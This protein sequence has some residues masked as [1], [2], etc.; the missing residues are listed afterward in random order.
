MGNP[1]KLSRM[2]FD[3]EAYPSVFDVRHNLR[4]LQQDNPMMERHV[5]ERTASPSKG[6]EED[7]GLL[8]SSV[9]LRGGRQYGRYDSDLDLVSA[10]DREMNR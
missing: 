3:V 6:F 8:D 4:Q 7:E 9:R 10:G 1:T 2:S 5:A